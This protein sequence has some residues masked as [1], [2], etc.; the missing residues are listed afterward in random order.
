MVISE[1]YIFFAYWLNQSYSAVCTRV[2]CF[3]RNK[4]LSMKGHRKYFCATATRMPHQ[5]MNLQTRT[6]TL[7][8]ERGRNFKDH[9]H[10]QLKR[11]FQ[12]HALL[13]M[14]ACPCL[15]VNVHNIFSN[16]MLFHQIKKLTGCSDV[17][18]P[19]VMMFAYFEEELKK[20]DNFP[21]I[22][23]RVVVV[24][25]LVWSLENEGAISTSSLRLLF[26]F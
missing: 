13:S 26:S 7:Y 3:N 4:I 23:S 15:I 10:R 25:R 24:Q 16:L 12:K 22:I 21:N 19:F 17:K 1:L 14:C 2:I 11:C 20:M 6:Q 18:T 9:N 5:A 8:W